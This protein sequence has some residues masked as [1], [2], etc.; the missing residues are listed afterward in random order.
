MAFPNILNGSIGTGVKSLYYFVMFEI[1]DP[2]ITVVAIALG[3]LI[4]VNS[5]LELGYQFKNIL[6]KLLLL[7][8]LSNISFFLLQ[9]FLYIGSLLYRQLWSFGVPDHT[10]SSGQD[11]LAELEIG[12]NAGSILSFLI[13]MIFLSLMLYLLLFLSLRLAIIYTLP[14]I[15]PVLTLL[16]II[17]GTNELGERI[18]FIFIDAIVAPILTGI[19]LILATYVVNDS[20]LVLG[21]ITLADLIPIMLSFGQNSRFSGLFLGKS[22]NAGVERSKSMV[23]GGI[24]KGAPL[25]AKVPESNG[26]SGKTQEIG[27][28]RKYTPLNEQNN[29][30]S[31]LFFKVRRE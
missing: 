19:P 23:I 11:I 18:W 12:G 2:V 5:S 13:I 22:V 16:I 1:Y 24:R 15:A 7:L 31:S 6:I 9:D 3:I 28:V 20:V 14:I 10:F 25:S 4:L 27:S 29:G 30:N 21:F 17:P 26:T 8:V